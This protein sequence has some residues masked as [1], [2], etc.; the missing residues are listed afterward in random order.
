MLFNKTLISRP[1]LTN[2]VMSRLLPLPACQSITLAMRSPRSVL[3][4]FVQ[5]RILMFKFTRKISRHIQDA[6]FLQL[7][8]SINVQVCN[9]MYISNATHRR[10]T[11]KNMWRFKKPLTRNMS[12]LNK[13]HNH[14]D[15]MVYNFIL[16]IWQ[17]QKKIVQFFLFTDIFN[18]WSTAILHKI[19]SIHFKN[20]EPLW[21]FDLLINVNLTKYSKAKYARWK[22]SILCH[23]WFV[24]DF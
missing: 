9:L 3:K 23:F 1:L 2:C 8:L 17:I 11:R 7:I 12:I 15:A 4:P 20:R 14:N 19:Y 13:L 22:S 24:I 5:G 6:K 10:F 21:L 18:L 16:C